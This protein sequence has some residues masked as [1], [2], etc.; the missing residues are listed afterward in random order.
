MATGLLN[1]PISRVNP[2]SRES[3]SFSGSEAVHV[4]ETN[5]FA[6]VFVMELDSANNNLIVEYAI[7]GSGTFRNISTNASASPAY[8]PD[9][10]DLAE[11]S[12]VVPPSYVVPKGSTIRVSAASGGA[13]RYLIQVVSY[14]S[15]A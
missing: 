10:D 2:Y 5:E 13:H 14:N 1:A 3:G 11:V 9:I 12:G 15:P 4:L 7:S 8:S 6:Q